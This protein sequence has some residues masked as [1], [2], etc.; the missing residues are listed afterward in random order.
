MNFWNCTIASPLSLPS[1]SSLDPPSLTLE[2]GPLKSSYEVWGALQAPQ[3]G[4][5]CILALKFDIW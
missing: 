3:R 5:R 4:I 1:L 2:G